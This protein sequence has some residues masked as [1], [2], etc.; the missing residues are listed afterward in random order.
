MKS[1]RTRCLDS[2]SYENVRSLS[3]RLFVET[4]LDFKSE[5]SS[6]LPGSGQGMSYLC[7]FCDKNMYDSRQASVL[8]VKCGSR[9]HQKCAKLTDKQLD[10]LASKA[11]QKSFTCDCCV[12]TLTS[13]VRRWQA[14]WL[15]ELYLL[16]TCNI[17]QWNT[18][19]GKQTLGARQ[20]TISWLPF[21]SDRALL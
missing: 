2:L 19:P 15:F 1:L 11:L 21:L 7:C 16:F 5:K 13:T 9:N 14:F 8:C 20:A 17:Y 3:V 18:A 10:A 6:L 12:F 4:S